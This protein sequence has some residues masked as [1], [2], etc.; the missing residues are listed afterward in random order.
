MSPGRT[1]TSGSAS[2]ATRPDGRERRRARQPGG[3]RGDPA[4]ARRRQAGGGS[5]VAC[6]LYDWARRSSRSFTSVAA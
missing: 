2:P 5:E 6:H 1:R 3:G 4:A